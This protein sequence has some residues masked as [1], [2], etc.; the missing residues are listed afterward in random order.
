MLKLNS[1]NGRDL[2]QFLSILNQCES[3]GVTDIRFVRERLQNHIRERFKVGRIT[4]S[5]IAVKMAAKIE[6]CPSCGKRTWLP[7]TTIDGLRR[8]GCAE[9]KYS[10]VIK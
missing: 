9:C 5:K 1:Y 8:K 7:T 6:I 4:E 3:V 10:E 2:Q